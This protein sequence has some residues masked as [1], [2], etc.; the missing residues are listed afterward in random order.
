MTDFS[1]STP[2][3]AMAAARGLRLVSLCLATLL[4]C[5]ASPTE[6]R[7]Q[8]PEEQPP[9]SVLGSLAQALGLTPRE[10]RDRGFRLLPPPPSPPGPG[11]AAS[12]SPR[13]L[14][15]LREATGE[16]V[17]LGRLDREALCP[18]AAAQVAPPPPAPA[19]LFGGAA[20]AAV[21]GPVASGRE[22]PAACSVVLDAVLERPRRSAVRVVL[23]I[24]DVND[25][26]PR[27]DAG[28]R[29][30]DGDDGDD[31]DGEEEEGGCAR[32]AVSESARP[33][34]RFALPA[35]HDADAG[36]NARLRYALNASDAFY[37][38]VSRGDDDDGDDDDGGD[39]DSGG[40]GGGFPELVLRR[41]L[42]RERQA[43]H[44]LRLTATDGGSPAR[45]GVCGVVVR[46][47][48]ANDNAPAFE[49]PHYRVE[50]REGAPLGTEVARVRAIDPDEGTNGR[51]AYALSRHA[52]E[53]ARR[54]FSIEPLSGVVRLAAPL[55]R[56]RRAVEE[57]YVEAR[58]MGPDGVAAHCKVTVAVLDDNDNAPEIFVSAPTDGGGAG[59]GAGAPSSP[60]VAVV[61]VGESRPPG[62]FVAFVRVADGDAGDNGRVECVLRG[63]GPFALRPSFENGFALVT[64]DALDRERAGRF[65][66]TVVARD[67][68]RPPLESSKEITVIVADEND[69]APRFGAPSYRAS[70]SENNAANAPILAVSARDPDEGENGRVSYSIGAGEAGGLPAA[71]LVSVDERSGE[72]RALRPFDHERLQSLSFEVVARDHGSPALSATATVAVDVLDRNDNAPAVSR[73]RLRRGNATVY[74]LWS[75]PAEAQLARIQAVDED[76]GDN[77]K[78]AFRL[79]RGNDGGL[80]RLDGD[81]GELAT[82]RDFAEGDRASHE[83]LVEV[84]D[85]GKPSLSSL[86]TIHVV[87]TDIIPAHY[88]RDGGDDGDDDDDGGLFM[89]LPLILIV[90]LAA[91]CSVLLITM[92]VVAV[93]CKRENKEMRTYN[94]RAAETTYCR[95]PEKNGGGGEA[96]R[97]LPSSS[98]PG[99]V[100]A[101]PPDV[102]LGLGAPMP[103]G[104]ML[105]LGARASLERLSRLLA[106][107]SGGRGGG[108]QVDIAREHAWMADETESLPA[109]YPALG[110]AA[111]GSMRTFRCWDEATSAAAAA[112]GAAARYGSPVRDT[113]MPS[114]EHRLKFP[115]DAFRRV[116]TEADGISG[117]DSG[118]G[119]DPRDSDP[120]DADSDAEGAAAG[121]RAAAEMPPPP[122][123]PPVTA[124]DGA[125]GGRRV[126]LGAGP[127]C[128]SRPLRP[129]LARRKA[130]TPTWELMPHR[131]ARC[132]CPTPTPPSASAAATPGGSPA[133]RRRHHHNHHHHGHAAEADG[134]RRRRMAISHQDVSAS[135]PRHN[136]NYHNN[137]NYYQQQ[138]PQDDELPI[139]RH[140][141]TA[142]YH[143]VKRA[144][145]GP[146]RRS[147]VNPAVP[148]MSR[149]I[150]ECMQAYSSGTL[151]DGTGKAL[152]SRRTSS[153]SSSS[154]SS[155]EEGG[156]GGEGDGRGGRSVR[157]HRCGVAAGADG[158]RG[159]AGGG[160]ACGARDALAL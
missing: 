96:E 12:S 14:V 81:T 88:H 80:F 46:V 41:P 3:R 34:T 160:P 137:N 11:G 16:L 98:E 60:D 126:A 2:G 94:C 139:P 76:P 138:Q 107:T 50:V 5:H 108:S 7:L 157:F 42:D 135:N 119:S 105:G 132:L 69:N 83:L 66:V 158:A 122:P 29:R 22:E 136:N 78:L 26:A 1:F 21:G 35:A 30:D 17:S 124:A 140:H 73:P 133:Q 40:G 49:R 144:N 65:N 109:C 149:F 116:C 89:G 70:L 37:L 33:G 4:C 134:G 71:A 53:R 91:V 127:L 15:R 117:K 115:T 57:L 120:G 56:E 150:G 31:G 154:S 18:A 9:G 51:V 128:S 90:A 39:G 129:D 147:L 10:L 145:S 153:S 95:K 68:G 130:T 8:V 28:S 58:D 104:V 141:A 25:N 97:G 32:V 36:P 43:E 121:I 125:A 142:R 131:D 20:V 85:H 111:R 52:G 45:V 19:S 63:A 48:D 44:R 106:E 112:A 93:V 114:N 27:F 23:D 74:A 55:D 159:A 38:R 155:D 24:L 152:A 77:G 54:L 59:A 13:L 84:R 148:E 62:S 123:P 99:G 146:Q 6:L 151:A 79:L 75:T 67:A 47:L 118:R 103:P 87:L 92:V 113:L 61:T 101:P 143:H 82:T 102:M 100:G 86:A 110:G 156:G 64:S 72:V